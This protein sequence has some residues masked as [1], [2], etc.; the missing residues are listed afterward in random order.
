MLATILLSIT[1]SITKQPEVIKPIH[2]DPYSI[3]SD[4]RGTAIVEFRIDKE[5]KVG[6]VTI[7]DTFDVNTNHTIKDAVRQMRFTPALQNGRPV[8]VHYRLPILV[9]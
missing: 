4:Q 2:I 8:E 9:K 7:I 1:L 5:G 6:E 3:Y